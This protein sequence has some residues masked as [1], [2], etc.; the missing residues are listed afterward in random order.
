MCGEGMKLKEDETRET[1]R[2]VLTRRTLLME[3]R[4]CLAHAE[5][6]AIAQDSSPLTHALRSLSLSN[7]LFS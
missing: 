6:K 1:E 3:T 5:C 4:E 7:S 2:E